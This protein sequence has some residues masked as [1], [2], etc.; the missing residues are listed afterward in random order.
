MV[1]LYT[2]AAQIRDAHPRKYKRLYFEESRLGILRVESEVAGVSVL[3]TPL[4]NTFIVDFSWRTRTSWGEHEDVEVWMG[5][6]RDPVAAVHHAIELS[7]W[8]E[9]DIQDHF[10]RVGLPHKQASLL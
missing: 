1:D 4:T 3:V 10:A 7:E 9:L 8:S 2:I 6:H 5:E